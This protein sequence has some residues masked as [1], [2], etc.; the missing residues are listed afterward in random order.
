MA[1]Q[2]KKN[3]VGGNWKCNKTLSELTDLVKGIQGGMDG[4]NVDVIVSPSPC[5]LA[6]IAAACAGSGVMCSAQNM[7]ATGFGA[8]TGEIAPDQLKDLG[9]GWTI[10]GHSERRKYYGESN[11]EV[12]TKVANA[13]ANGLKVIACFGETKL[14]RD[15]KCTDQINQ[16]SLAAIIKGVPADKWCDVVLAYEPVWAI[17]TGDVC[18]EDEAERVCG[19]LRKFVSNMVNPQV[20]QAVRIIYG[21]SVK[22]KN[23]QALIAKPNIDGFLVG[24]AAL[25]VDTF[26]PIIKSASKRKLRS[27][28]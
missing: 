15:D 7:S 11:D 8:F 3:F 21:G 28:L 25:K 1:E 10:V 4:M 27:M 5:Y 6:N 20:A 14:Q 18:G 12:T 2:A 22:P 13:L 24:G 19:M 17:G 16:I 23:C 9:I 26:V